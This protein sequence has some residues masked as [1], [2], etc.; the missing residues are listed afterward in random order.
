[1]LVER[2]PP[3]ASLGMGNRTRQYVELKQLK[4]L[5]RERKAWVESLTTI[6]IAFLAKK[7]GI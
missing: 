3:L 7:V 6:D 2:A 1:M 4:L 5:H